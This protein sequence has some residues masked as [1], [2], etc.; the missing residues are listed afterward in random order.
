M[1]KESKDLGRL[2]GGG[3]T[4]IKPRATTDMDVGEMGEE[5]ARVYRR[6]RHLSPTFLPGGLLLSHIPLHHADHP[7]LPRSDAARSQGG[8][9]LLHHTQ[10][11]QAVRL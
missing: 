10:L 6:R 8:H 11:P 7:V 2:P 4:G 5:E 1:A 3:R 9:P